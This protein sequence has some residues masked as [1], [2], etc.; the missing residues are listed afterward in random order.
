MLPNSLISVFSE[1]LWGD[2][3]VLLGRERGL[4]TVT[5]LWDPGNADSW[6]RQGQTKFAPWKDM[7]PVEL[8]QL[9]I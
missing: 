4:Q 9:V 5:E 6:G 3:A 2:A 8:G 1:L 7:A